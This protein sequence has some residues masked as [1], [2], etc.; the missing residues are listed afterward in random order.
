MSILTAPTIE[1]RSIFRL[2]AHGLAMPGPNFLAQAEN[3]GDT[4]EIKGTGKDAKLVKAGSTLRTMYK[5]ALYSGNFQ[6][7]VHY[8][9]GM[10]PRLSP[11]IPGHLWHKRAALGPRRAKVMVIGKHPGET[12]IQFKRNFRGKSGIMLVETLQR[13]GFDERTRA[14]FY[15]TNLVKYENPDPKRGSAIKSAWVKDCWPLLQQELRIVRPDYILCLGADAAKQLLGRNTSVTSMEGRVEPYR[16][17]VDPD[18]L[19]PD[20]EPTYHESLVMVAHHPA[21]VLRFPVQQVSFDRS[22]SR[23]GQLIRGVRFDLEEPGI[24]HRVIDNID[25]LHS[26]GVEIEQ[27]CPDRLVAVDAEWHGEHPQKTL[28]YGKV[29]KPY[30]RTIQLSW[31]HKKAACIRLRHQGG[32]RA[33]RGGIKNAG[34]AGAVHGPRSSDQQTPRL[35]PDRHQGWSRHGPHGPRDPRGRPPGPGGLVDPLH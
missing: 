19:G 31:A 18:E 29:T 26:L 15:V 30:L 8:R 27:D 24:D 3:L 9:N 23:F 33:F 13:L 1:R 16:F 10:D 34:P 35:G 6:L 14:R 7:N 22:L 11:I 4:T 2:K 12:E 32:K 21:S 5:D 17:C 25:D 20:Q 28:K